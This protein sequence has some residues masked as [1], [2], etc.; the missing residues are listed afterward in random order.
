MCRV[1]LEGVVLVEGLLLRSIEK[2]DIS[3]APSIQQEYQRDENKSA[4]PFEKSEVYSMHFARESSISIPTLT[5][6]PIFCR[7][8]SMVT[9]DSIAS[10]NIDAA[11]GGIA[12]NCTTRTFRFRGRPLQS[13]LK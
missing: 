5:V 12:T 6:V 8:H 10:G 2:L 9:L 1:R 11:I 13:A 3:A 4:I 7:I